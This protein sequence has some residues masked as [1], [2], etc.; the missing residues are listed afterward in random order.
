MNLQSP[1][2]LKVGGH[3]E[4]K[5]SLFFNVQMC[6]LRSKKLTDRSKVKPD[7]SISFA[8]VDILEANTPSEDSQEMRYYIFDPVKY[9]IEDQK[10]SWD[11]LR[12]DLTDA[13]CHSGAKFTSKQGESWGGKNGIKND[14]K[15]SGMICN[16]SRTYRD[17]GRYKKLSG[18]MKVSTCNNTRKNKNRYNGHVG[19]PR[20]SSTLKPVSSDGVC[21]CPRFKIWN[22]SHCFFM[23]VPTEDRMHTNHGSKSYEELKAGS[24][25]IPKEVESHRKI[26]SMATS[27]SNSQAKGLRNLHNVM[28]RRTLSE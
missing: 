19:Q 14:F 20:V 25:K 23:D 3:L 22:N 21:K 2:K 27:S 4:F 28:Q 18:L 9:P 7:M 13:S 26:M 1:S 12:E 17:G 6:S 11:A 8:T 24:S 16:M 10:R 15:W 5:A